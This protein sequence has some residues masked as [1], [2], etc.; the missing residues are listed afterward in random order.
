MSAIS[1][2][3][4]SAPAFKVGDAVVCRGNPHQ[5]FTV[6]KINAFHDLYVCHD[7]GRVYVQEDDLRLRLPEETERKLRDAFDER[8]RLTEQGRAIEAR[9]ARYWTDE[10]LPIEAALTGQAYEPPPAGCLRVRSL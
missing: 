8:D 7:A 1:E 6:A 4:R 2:D 5:G 3:A 10:Y 9:R